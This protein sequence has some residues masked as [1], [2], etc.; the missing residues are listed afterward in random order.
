MTRQLIIYEIHLLPPPPLPSLQPL[1]NFNSHYPV[2]KVIEIGM[3]IKGIISRGKKEIKLCKIM[4]SLAVC[5]M[6]NSNGYVVLAILFFHILIK[7]KT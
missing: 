7:I 4:S 3:R 5:T 1:K 6:A 2:Y